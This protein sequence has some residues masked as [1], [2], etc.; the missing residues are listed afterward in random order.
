MTTTTA[1]GGGNI[2]LD[3]IVRWTLDPDGDLYGD[4]RERLRW[5]EGIAVAAGLQWLA[6]PW[7][8]AALVWV[9]GRSAVLPLAVMVATLYLPILVCAGYVRRRRVETRV[10]HWTPKRVL[11]AALS[12]L[13]YLLFFLGCLRALQPPGSSATRG[14]AIGMLVGGIVGI[15]F[16]RLAA[17]RRRRSAVVGDDD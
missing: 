11:L 3:R 5:Y 7:A 12:G 13:P 6:I 14:A 4:E 15:L 8:A 16:A 1:A 9:I 10:H 2:L 17:R